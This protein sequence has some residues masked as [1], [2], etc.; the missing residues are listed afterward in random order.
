MTDT[1]NKT[2]DIYIRSWFCHR[3]K[4]EVYQLRCPICGKTRRE[5]SFV[6]PASNWVEVIDEASP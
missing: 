3:C 6:S 4:V 2:R 5:K 1:P